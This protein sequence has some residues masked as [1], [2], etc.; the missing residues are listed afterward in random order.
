[1]INQVVLIGRIVKNIDDSDD[2]MT[3]AVSRSYKNE[4]GEYE[5]DIIN[6]FINGHVAEATKEYCHK[7]DLIG[8]RGFVQ[9]SIKDEIRYTNI[10]ANKISFL[11]STESNSRK[12]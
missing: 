2:Y 4:N 3:I 11:S 1:M 9:T 8:V 6:V 7:G 10:I 12:Y 5:N